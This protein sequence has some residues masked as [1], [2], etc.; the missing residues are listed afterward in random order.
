MKYDVWVY[1]K[2]PTGH[3]EQYFGEV[4]GDAGEIMDALKVLYA[5]DMVGADI[6]T[7]ECGETEE[8]ND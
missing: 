6:H 7:L 8:D 5:P 4:T 3:K 1:L 2:T